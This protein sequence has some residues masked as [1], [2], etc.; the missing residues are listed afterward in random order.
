LA[1]ILSFRVTNTSP[2]KPR[3][4]GGFPNQMD[5]DSVRD[6][7]LR[8]GEQPWASRLKSREPT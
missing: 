2:P 3:L 1:V 5:V 7:T 4:S 6:D 8:T